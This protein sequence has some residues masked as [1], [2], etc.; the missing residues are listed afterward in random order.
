MF[1]KIKEQIVWFFYDRIIT[2]YHIFRIRKKEKINV[3]FILTNISIW[4]TELLYQKM[5]RHP[6]FNP[7]LGIVPTHVDSEEAYNEVIRYCEKKKYTYTEISIDKSLTEQTGCDLILYSEP[8]YQNYYDK[9][10]F[11][12]NL[13]A[14]V[15][16][17]AYGVPA[18]LEEWNINIPLYLHCWQYYFQDKEVAHDFAMRMHNYG[19]NLIVTGLPMFDE[20]ISYLSAEDPWKQLEGKRRKRVIYAPHHSIGS[21]L[22]E[23]VK[24]MNYSTFLEYGEFMLE[25]AEKYKN[26]IQ[27]VFKPHPYLQAKLTT[28][29]GEEKTKNYYK[30]WEE[31]ET[32]QYETGKY[33]SLFM[34]SDAMIHDCGTFTYEYHYT[35]NPVMYL[36]KE[37]NHDENLTSSMKEAYNLHYK[38]YK[39]EDI[40]QF[41]LDIINGKDPMR[42]KR[43]D[44]Y[45][46]KLLPPHGKT[47]C[48]NIIDAILG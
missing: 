26:E 23:D 29:W 9:H 2:P 47:A 39:K 18:I 48:E 44:F 28:V 46:Q 15:V 24:G 25:M 35:K 16:H 20:F 22:Y 10:I 37:D 27:F 45:N 3:L 12:H 5:M 19:K 7:I 32:C 21:T 41:L 43:E 17:I 38:A 34:T 40:E 8:Y 30:R 33:V 4:K 36:V 31:F 1:S 14:L 11:V 13:K 42:K 6:R